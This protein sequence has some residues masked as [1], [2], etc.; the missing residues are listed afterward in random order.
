MSEMIQPAETGTT[1]QTN[2]NDDNLL[3]KLEEYRHLR[4][5][6]G[7]RINLS[8]K[9]DSA[10]AKATNATKAKKMPHFEPRTS[11]ILRG[12]ICKDLSSK[13]YSTVDVTQCL[14]KST[15]AN[16]FRCQG[17]K[18]RANITSPKQVSPAC[19]KINRAP[20][21]F[22]FAKLKKVKSVH[23]LSEHATDSLGTQQL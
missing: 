4:N 5:G 15:Q 9:T 2:A 14:S 1:K 3:S 10:I 22:F 20:T 13:N 18:N 21:K 19:Q 23:N 8:L 6:S 17:L 12:N 11:K 16:S 7:G